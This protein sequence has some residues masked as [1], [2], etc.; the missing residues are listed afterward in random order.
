[1]T[2]RASAIAALLAATA[3]LACAQNVPPATAYVPP[4]FATSGDAD[5]D[6]WRVRFAADAVNV[7]NLP[8]ALV[9]AN[10]AGLTPDP[11]VVRLNARQPEFVRPVW[12]YLSSAIS[13]ARISQGRSLVASQRATL[14]DT[15]ERTGVPV[16]VAVAIWGME[17][18]FGSIKGS[19]DVLRSLSTLAYAGRRTELGNRELINAL[20]IMDRGEAR[21]SDLI[22]SWAGAMGHTQFMPS[23]FLE[24]AVDGDGDGKRDIWNDSFDALAS[25]M[26]YLSQRGW[27]AGEPWGFQVRLPSDF[28]WALLDGTKR[29]VAVWQQAGVVA[30]DGSLA[31]PEGMQV[32]LL[33]PAGAG[34]PAFLVGS[35]YES[36][37]NYNN[38]DSYALAVAFLSDRFAGRTPMTGGWPTDNPPLGG[39]TARELQTL[40]NA[41]GFD[42]G[43]PDGVIGRRT[44]AQLRAFQASRGLIS[45]GYA[46]GAALQALRDAM[47][48]ATP[49]AARNPEVAPEA[50]SGGVPIPPNLSA[51]APPA[52]RPRL[53]P[54]PVRMFGPE[55][56]RP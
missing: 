8:P 7:H 24:L 45:D 25:T 9:E 1:M 51:P 47:A 31:M 28:D 38:S 53:T 39:A 29:D 20:R 33:V 18:S 32:R 22:G 35:G 49:E 15:A 10:L 23:S 3:T 50:P 55:V 30:V 54:E 40:L 26:N 43:E 14:A 56:P 4:A 41:L 44:R 5:F 2:F 6:A 42:V 12:D 11:T 27:K 17:S 34:G 21:R 48:Q 46:S 37:L 36:I 19:M 16:E 13:E 52:I